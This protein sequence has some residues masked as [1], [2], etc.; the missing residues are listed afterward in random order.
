[1]KT[2]ISIPDSLFSAAERLASRL[3]IS[4]SLLYQRALSSYI[5]KHKADGVTEALDELYG[6][7]GVS[8]ELD[9]VIEYL[10]GASIAKE[11]W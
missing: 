7:G 8:S 11:E 5:E 2:A 10:Q 1:M 4:R 9:P 6:A 3:G